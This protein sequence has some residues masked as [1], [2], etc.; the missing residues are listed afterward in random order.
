MTADARRVTVEL[1]AEGCDPV[2]REGELT[3]FAL[4]KRGLRAGTVLIGAML[5]AGAIIPI[6]IVHLVGIPLILGIGIA[7]AV[8]QFRSVARLAPMRMPCPKCGADNLMGGGLGYRS[9]TG[10]INRNCESCRRPLA[11]RF[12]SAS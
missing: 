2:C 7:V 8:R 3:T 4:G 1:R 11:L 12:L 9:A 5:L 6:P 10:P